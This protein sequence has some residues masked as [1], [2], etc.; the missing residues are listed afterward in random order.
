MT[1]QTTLR[2]ILEALELDQEIA[3]DIEKSFSGE[4]KVL[5]VSQSTP[6][7]VRKASTNKLTVDQARQVIALAKEERPQAAAP[8][9]PPPPPP[10]GEAEEIDEVVRGKIAPEGT[11][12][13][14]QTMRANAKVAKQFGLKPTPYRGCSFCHEDLDEA[15]ELEGIPVTEMGECPF[16]TAIFVPEE[17]V[18]CYSC[19]TKMTASGKCLKCGAKRTDVEELK[20]A[21]AYVR[22]EE[23]KTGAPARIQAQQYLADAGFKVRMLAQARAGKWL[24]QYEEDGSDTQPGSINTQTP[25]FVT[26]AIDVIH[27]ASQ[28]YYK[29]D[30]T[31]KTIRDQIRSASTTLLQH[32]K[33]I[34]ALDRQA[35]M[36]G[37]KN[38]PLGTINA[39]AETEQTIIA[40][41]AEIKSYFERGFEYQV[42]AAAIEMGQTSFVQGLEGSAMRRGY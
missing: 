18:F 24:R 27:K 25:G 6:L 17:K 23:K 37:V 11:T 31:G 9:T 3:A 8:N 13:T 29:I 1:N 14:V 2:D 32:L 36:A 41:T 34:G 38:V 12:A 16:C 4:D 26:D 19:G 35:S 20:H 40:L 30:I 42:I 39:A 10:A 22:H 7:A 5:E 15:S 21:V 33:N 28:F